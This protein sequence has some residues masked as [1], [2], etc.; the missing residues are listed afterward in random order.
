M[1]AWVWIPE[2]RAAEVEEND[3]IPYSSWREA[4][5]V[6][7]TPGDAVDYSAILRTIEAAAD[8]FSIQRLGFDPWNSHHLI[9]L[10][11][12]DLGLECNQVAQGFRQLNAPAKRL[13][14]L[15]RRGQLRHN[16]SPALRWTAGN[17]TVADDGSGN[18]RPKKARRGSVHKM[19]PISSLCN[20]LAVELAGPANPPSVYEG[21]GLKTI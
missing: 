9:Q 3:A 7:F 2:E 18:I 1:L 16:R 10:I 20:A 5:W 11:G 21:G 19:D 17:A 8:R 6:E 15:L 4:G 12:E 13:E 14:W